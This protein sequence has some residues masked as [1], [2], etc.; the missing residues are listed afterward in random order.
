[1][2]VIPISSRGTRRSV[3]AQRVYS[4]SS[5]R[6]HAEVPRS[7]LQ[8][9]SADATEYRRCHYVQRSLVNRTMRKADDSTRRD[10]VSLSVC[11]WQVR[12]LGTGTGAQPLT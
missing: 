3:G 7:F 10:C 4:G 11:T 12:P 5:I 6:G 9:N 1:M 2:A 8:V